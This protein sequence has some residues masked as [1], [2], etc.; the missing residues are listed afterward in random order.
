M[1]RGPVAAEV[2]DKAK[3]MFIKRNK[4]LYRWLHPGA[5]RS[6][7]DS[8]LSAAWDALPAAEKGLYISEV[9]AHVAISVLLCPFASTARQ[10][11]FA[12][13]SIQV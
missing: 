11:S 1:A 3:K 8:T 2:L 6:F 13:Y 4:T 7:L 12:C 10:T 9:T 5:T